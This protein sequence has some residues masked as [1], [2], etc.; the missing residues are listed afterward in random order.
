[1]YGRGLSAGLVCRKIASYKGLGAVLIMI[2]I[3]GLRADL[4]GGRRAASRLARS[5]RGASAARTSAVA[6]SGHNAGCDCNGC[7]SGPA[8]AH[9]ANCNCCRPGNSTRGY[10]TNRGVMFMVRRTPLLAR[11][12][13]SSRSIERLAHSDLIGG[14]VVARGEACLTLLS[15]HPELRSSAY[16]T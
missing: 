7:T 13:P 15:S 12:R 5:L 3:L 9:P 16:D 2:A 8:N 6:S 4:P 11:K 14:S 10:A 1:M